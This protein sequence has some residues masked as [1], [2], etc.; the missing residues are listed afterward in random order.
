MDTFHEDL[1]RLTL[2]EKNKSTFEDLK[3]LYVY[4]LTYQNEL[5]SK[6]TDLEQENRQLKKDLELSTINCKTAIKTIYNN[7]RKLAKIKKIMKHPRISGFQNTNILP[8]ID[9]VLQD[10]RFGR[11]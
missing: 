11:F 10:M 1:S 7:E 3:K 2:E 8:V 4:S 5:L 6:L 9:T